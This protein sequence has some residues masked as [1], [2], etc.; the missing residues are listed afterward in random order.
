MAPKNSLADKPTDGPAWV[1]Y[2]QDVFKESRK[3]AS[4]GKITVEQDFATQQEV[5]EHFAETYDECLTSHDG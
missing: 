1:K 4:E 5:Y 3:L 2:G